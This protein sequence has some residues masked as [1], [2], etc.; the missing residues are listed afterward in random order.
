MIGASLMRPRE[1][2][3]QLGAA[4]SEGSAG[5]RLGIVEFVDVPR[6]S[7][8]RDCTWLVDPRALSAGSASGGAP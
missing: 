4:A 3:F 6:W 2:I 7:R 1:V 5:R 8:N